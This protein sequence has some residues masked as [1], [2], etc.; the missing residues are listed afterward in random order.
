MSGGA[1]RGTSSYTTVEHITECLCDKE[2]QQKVCVCVYDIIG[3]QDTC[4]KLTGGATN[5]DQHSIIII[6]IFD[7]TIL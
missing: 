4:T 5:S 3:R 2:M 7:L 1:V 6:K